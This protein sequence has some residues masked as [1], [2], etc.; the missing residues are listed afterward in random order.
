MLLPVNFISGTEIAF[1]IF[2]VVMLFGAEKIPEIARGLAKGMKMIRNATN[3]I[4]T[5]I[6]RSVEDQFDEKGGKDI[7]DEIDKVKKD[8]EDITGT[9]KRRHF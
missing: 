4:K 7:K 1:I 3:D 6:T 9:I 8:I 2:I 5:E